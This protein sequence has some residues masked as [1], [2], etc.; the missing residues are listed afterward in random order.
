N[1]ALYERAQIEPAM[2]SLMASIPHL[3]Y[4]LAVVDIA[5]TLGVTLSVATEAFFRVGESLKLNRMS[6]RLVNLTV[7]SRWQALA[8]ESFVDDLE[9]QQALLTSSVLRLMQKESLSISEGIA[10]W[11][12]SQDVMIHRWSK[13]VSQ[14]SAGDVGDYALYQVAI[15]ELMDLAQSSERH[16]QVS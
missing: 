11:H 2:A 8:R 14:I 6:E 7:G 3:F 16:A 5:H 4:Y 12:E 13:M 9:R 10:R 1:Q 15:R